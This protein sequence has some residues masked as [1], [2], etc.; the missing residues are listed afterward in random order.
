LWNTLQRLENAHRLIFLPERTQ[1]LGLPESR[2]KA[3]GG[4]FIRRDL[5]VERERAC[6][7]I[8]AGQGLGMPKRRFGVG[9]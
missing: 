3:Q 4:L 8:E 6:P 9:R 5:G 1:R 7:T 2:L